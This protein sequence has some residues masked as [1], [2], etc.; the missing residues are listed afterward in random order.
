MSGGLDARLA[1]AGLLLSGRPDARSATKGA[2]VATYLTGLRC[3]ACGAEYPA[4]ARS[5]CEECFGPLEP[6]YDLERIRAEVSRRTIDSGPP[7]LWRFVPLLPASP[8]ARVDLGDGWTPLRH[9]ERLGAR[10]GAAPAVRE[11]RDA[12]PD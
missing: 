9:A 4:E 5:I 12:E 1:S 3:R 10:A 7:S 11:G 2:I 6:S 8:D